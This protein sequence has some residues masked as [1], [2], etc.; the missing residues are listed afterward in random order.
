MKK[1]TPEQYRLLK[2]INWD[3]SIPVDDMF[4]VLNGEKP[5]AGHWN[6]DDL[7]LRMLDKLS[8]YE[9]LE[10]FTPETMADKLTPDILEKIHNKEKRTKYERLGKILRGEAVSFTKWGPEYRKECKDAL[11]SNRW[12]ST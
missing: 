9:L 5:S 8:W 6:A 11:F 4:A 1:I 3:Y 12:Y 2:R 10:F 7:L